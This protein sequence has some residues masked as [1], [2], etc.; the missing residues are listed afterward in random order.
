MKR[1]GKWKGTE[2][3]GGK[4][5]GD[6]MGIGIRKVQRKKRRTEREKGMRKKRE[7]EKKR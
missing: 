4:D 5:K 3:V 6:G 7:N 1:R 2:K